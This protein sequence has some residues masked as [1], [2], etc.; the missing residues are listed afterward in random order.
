MSL[1]LIHIPVERRQ[2]RD[3]SG[4][5]QGGE[6]GSEE[7]VSG[8]RTSASCGPQGPVGVD[9]AARPVYAGGAVQANAS[10]PFSRFATA[11]PR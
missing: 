9:V 11:R 6:S 3:L 5:P 8:G 7:P 4:F 1:S 2:Y 10:T